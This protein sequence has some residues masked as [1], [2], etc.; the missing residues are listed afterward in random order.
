MDETCKGIQLVNSGER[1]GHRIRM[2]SIL[3][4]FVVRW[5]QGSRCRNCLLMKMLAYVGAGAD[6]GFSERG[7]LNI[8][9]I[10]EA[11]GLEG[12][13]PQKL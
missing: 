4:G 7:G 12:T 8:E 10:S 3:I 6:P 9:V 13:A 1:C 11:G 5:F 2:S